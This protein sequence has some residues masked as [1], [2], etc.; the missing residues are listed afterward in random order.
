MSL[1]ITGGSSTI[2]SGSSTYTLNGAPAGVAIVWSVSNPS[3]A[4]LSSSGNQVTVTMNGNGSIY[5]TATVGGACFTNNTTTTTIRL[6]TYLTSEFDI[7][8]EPVTQPF[9]KNQLITFGPAASELLAPSTYYNWSWGS[10]WTYVS[11]LNTR[12]LQLRVSNGNFYSGTVMLRAGNNCG[13]SDIK[14]KIFSFNPGC[15]SPYRVSPNPS[16]NLIRIEP[17]IDN[18]ETTVTEIREIEIID[19]SGQIKFKQKLSKGQI[20]MNLNVSFLP[21]DIYTLRIF[22][23][24]IWYSH[25]VVVLR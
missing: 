18:K 4:S 12:Y 11:G 24:E 19:R 13:T 9:C 22:D 17:Q 20:Q 2:C 14:Y 8:S 6:G 5:L 21:S 7:Y 1:S 23:G 10:G 3:I 25:K 16:T 15:N